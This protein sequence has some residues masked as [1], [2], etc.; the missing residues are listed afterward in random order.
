[1]LVCSGLRAVA[2]ESG[3][4]NGRGGRGGAGRQGRGDMGSG[5]EKKAN[6][7]SWQIG[8]RKKKQTF[9]SVPE[10]DLKV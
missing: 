8:E 4:R 9:T 1:M 2:R 5:A 3:S 10:M 6:F 7:A